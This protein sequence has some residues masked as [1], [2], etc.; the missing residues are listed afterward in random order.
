MN[1][2]NT[3]STQIWNCY[4]RNYFL[5]EVEAIS[6]KS[7]MLL[8]VELWSKYNIL[9]S[10]VSVIPKVRDRYKYKIK[11]EVCTDYRVKYPN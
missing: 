5:G 9:M 1:V 2:A 7:A 3:D 10:E 4:A 8:A 11:L 6:S